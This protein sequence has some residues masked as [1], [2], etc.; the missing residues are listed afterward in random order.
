MTQRNRAKKGK[1]KMTGRPNVPTTI[2]EIPRELI[3]EAAKSYPEVRAKVTRRNLKGQWSGVGTVNFVT[4][5]LLDVDAWLLK[6]AGG[7]DYRVACTDPK[8]PAHAVIPP[9]MVSLEGAQRPFQQAVPS[10]SNPQHLTGSQPSLGG[11]AHTNANDPRRY[12]GRTPDEVATQGW[13]QADRDRQE[14]RRGRADERKRHEAELGTIRADYQRL[15]EKNAVDKAE[16]E[17]RV[18]EQQIQGLRDSQ[19]QGPKIDYVGIATAL[20]PV[21]VALISAGTNRTAALAELQASAASQTNATMQAVITSQSNGGDAFEK[22][23]AV[24]PLLT[25][26]ISKMIDSRDPSK[27]GELYQAMGDQILTQASM[28][29]QIYKDLHPPDEPAPPWLGI[30][31]SLADG[32]QDFAQGMISDQQRVMG[33]AP[34]NPSGGALSEAPQGPAATQPSQPTGEPQVVE[35][36]PSNAVPTESTDPQNRRMN[37][38]VAALDE[39]FQTQEFATVVYYLVGPPSDEVVRGASADL[40]E[41][42]KE[43][44]RDLCRAIVKDPKLMLE[45]FFDKLPIDDSYKLTLGGRF[46]EDMSTI[47]TP[48]PASDAQPSNGARPSPSGMLE[49]DDIPADA[50][51]DQTQN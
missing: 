23:L 47:V 2:Q 1:K 29:A 3:I 41:I 10:A 5:D 50:R 12:M 19:N 49:G 20:A 42:V 27:L 45:H 24:V 40:V 25:P 38:S 28:N 17:R 51:L 37:E 16:S 13:N 21:A 48:A 6:E 15:V 7:G 31:Q 33:G 35:S 39:A 30:V 36:A 9:F 4:S 8:N 14:E 44:D 34:P 46:V 43:R 26:F 18:F 32:V 11:P 22:I